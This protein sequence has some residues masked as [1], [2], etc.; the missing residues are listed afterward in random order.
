[1]TSLPSQP[2]T[3]QS[4]YELGRTIGV[5]LALTVLIWGIG[6]CISVGRR[7]GVNRPALIALMMVL[8]G[9]LVGVVLTRGA[10]SP[11]VAVPILMGG[12]A[13]VAVL[14][15]TEVILAIVVLRQLR[16]GPQAFRQGRSQARWACLLGV[17]V[18]AFLVL[19]TTEQLRRSPETRETFALR[20]ACD[21][22]CHVR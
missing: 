22:A 14:G 15:L 10:Q 21:E 20:S 12:C 6:K 9:W 3:W 19:G 4:G 18:P 8:L 11:A 1:M 7:T 2:G 17:L 16:R 13:I 5:G